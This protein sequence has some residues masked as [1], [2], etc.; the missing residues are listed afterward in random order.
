MPELALFV[1][2]GSLVAL[3]VSIWYT[4]SAYTMAL[5]ALTGVAASAP[6]ILGN[7]QKQLETQFSDLLL[8]VDSQD[9]KLVVW[10]SDIEALL[11]AVEGVLEHTERKRRSV[12]Q[13]ARRLDQDQPEQAPEP[14]DPM[15]MSRDQLTQLA[16]ARGVIQ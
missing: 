9:S 14:I 11:D 13:A 6:N 16:R 12:T 1:S 10:R 3:G 5:R 15:N 2:C 8:R 4:R 7:A